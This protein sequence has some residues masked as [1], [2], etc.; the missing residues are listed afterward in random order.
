MAA[1]VR[2]NR[3]KEVEMRFMRL[4]PATMLLAIAAAALVNYLSIESQSRHTSF[5]SCQS[6]K[7]VEMITSGGCAS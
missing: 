1:N 4:L 6:D 3:K 7:G 5:A 2:L